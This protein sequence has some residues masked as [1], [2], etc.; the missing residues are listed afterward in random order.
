LKDYLSA[1]YQ[2]IYKVRIFNL[3]VLSFFLMIILRS[4]SSKELIHEEWTMGITGNGYASHAW[5]GE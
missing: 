3:I 5:K 1:F 4:T 2:I